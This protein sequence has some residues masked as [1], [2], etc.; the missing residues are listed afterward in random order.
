MGF[1]G[2]LKGH[3]WAFRN[4]SNFETAIEAYDSD[5]I[6]RLVRESI[7]II[8]K[9][10]LSSKEKTIF[11]EIRKTYPKE[12]TIL[13]KKVLRVRVEREGIASLLNVMDEVLRLATELI[14]EYNESGKNE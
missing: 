4:Q 10:G 9:A 6:K 13:T 7:R 14:E 2:M 8:L 1:W 12:I 5:E 11:K 3:I